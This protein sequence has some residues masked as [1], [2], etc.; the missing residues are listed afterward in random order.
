MQTQ[1]GRAIMRPRRLDARGCPRSPSRPACSTASIRSHA[2]ANADRHLL[3]G[4]LA[5]QNGLVNQAQLV[6]A[7][8]AWT[9]DTGGALAEHLV[10]RGDLDADDR[11]AVEALVA[12][13]LRRYGDVEKSL[14]AVPVGKSTREGLA[15]IGNPTI[16]ATLGHVGS[17]PASTKDGDFDGT[18]TYSVGLATS[19]GQR[20]RVLRPHARGGLGAVFVALDTELHREV[21][22]KQILDHHA[23]DP[24]NLHCS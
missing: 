14:A 9:L 17:E 12:R 18:L 5:L 3:F 20:F 4:L 7:F 10:S 15:K 13:H 24:T 19:E 11:V 1:F 2:I 8:Q 23:D 16:D 6:A 21:A 22:L